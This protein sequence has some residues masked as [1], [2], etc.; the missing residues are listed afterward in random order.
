MSYIHV[1]QDGQT[2][3]SFLNTNGSATVTLLGEDLKLGENQIVVSAQNEYSEVG[4]NHL[5]VKELPVLSAIDILSPLTFFPFKDSYQ[6]NLDFRV[7]LVSG[8]SRELVGQGSIVLTDPKGKQLVRKNLTKTGS[9]PLIFKIPPNQVLFGNYKTVVTFT[10]K[11]GKTTTKTKVIS[12]SSKRMV[13]TSGSLTVS[14]WQ[15]VDDCGSSYDPCK[16]GSLSGSANGIG[17]YNDAISRDHE[18]YISIS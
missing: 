13:E 1:F 11:G 10:P 14:A 5:I 6:D 2:V 8:A 18:S 16:K 4:A 12:G 17:L 7:N 3:A 9:Y 15:A